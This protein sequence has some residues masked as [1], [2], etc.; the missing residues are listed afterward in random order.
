MT[1]TATIQIIPERLAAIVKLDHGS[2]HNLRDGMCAMEAAAY[3]AGEHWSDQPECVCPVIGAF[4][5]SWNDALPDSERT[6]LLLPLIPKIIGTRSDKAAEQRR[7]TM[8]ADWLI[9][10]HT[11]AWLQLAG[12]TSQAEALRA[13]PEI[14]DFAQCPSLMPTLNAVRKDAS[15][16]G[17]AAWAAVRDAARAAAGDAVW[18]AVWAAVRDAARDAAWDAAWDAVRAAAGVA[19]RAAV[20]AAVRDA[21]SKIKS[22][23]QQSAVV[24]VERMAEVQH[25]CPGR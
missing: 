5:R 14:T 18:A 12:L 7:A 6:T 19:V 11:P 2:H 8:A 17:D 23:L 15:A 9:R 20:W 3:V 22:E 16:A 25:P 4:M 21:L 24:L 10:V 13:L 1:P